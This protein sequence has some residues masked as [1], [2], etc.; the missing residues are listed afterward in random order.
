M[1]KKEFFRDLSEEYSVRYDHEFTVLF[2]RKMSIPITFD[3]YFTVKFRMYPM[4]YFRYNSVIL[5]DEM[6]LGKTIQT[7]AFL[8]YL[9]HQHQVYGPSLIVVPLSTV[10]AWQREFEQ[11]APEMNVLVY[12][13][14]IN[15]RLKVHVLKIII[16][17]HSNV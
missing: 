6:G 17:Y 12:L 15:S 3:R 8:S 14:D 5:A 7:I 13:G 2:E 4:A 1:K 10:V 16:H 9:Y 11:W